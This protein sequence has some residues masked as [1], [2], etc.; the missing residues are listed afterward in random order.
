MVHKEKPKARL[1]HKPISSA[2]RQSSLYQL[3]RLPHRS[4]SYLAMKMVFWSQEKFMMIG[5]PRA[6]PL[7][8]SARPVIL[9][10]GKRPLEPK[11]N[12][13]SSPTGKR[14]RYLIRKLAHMVMRRGP[15]KP[16][17]SDFIPSR[18]W[19]IRYLNKVRL[20]TL[21]ASICV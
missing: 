2:T 9:P 8:V 21:V 15:S 6:K 4:R 17:H 5:S 18:R 20:Q 13:K 10:T 3:L 14:E 11:G 19:I 7:L 1:Q 16:N 12:L